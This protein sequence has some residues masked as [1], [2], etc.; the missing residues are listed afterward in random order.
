MEDGEVQDENTI[1]IYDQALEWPGDDEAPERRVPRSPG[2]VF[3]LLVARSSI[4]PRSQRLA[5]I[6]TA[7]SEVQLGRDSAPVGSELPRIRLKE[8]EVSKVHATVYWDGER[9]EW[10]VVDMGSKHGTFFKSSSRLGTSGSGIGVDKGVRLS[11]ERIASVPRRLGHGDTLTIGGTAF[12]I[13][14]HEDG[15]PCGDCA[16]QGDDEIPLFNIRASRNQQDDGEQSHKRKIDNVDSVDAS[17]T[18]SSSG[19]DPKKAL[20]MLKKSLLSRHHLVD[21][22]A[23]FNGSKSRSPTPSNQY[24]D[25]SAKRRALYPSSAPDTP[26]VLTPSRATTASPRLS[27]PFL[28]APPPALPPAPVSAPPTPLAS[29]NIGHQLLMKQGWQPGTSLGDPRE[30]RV[31]AALIEPLEVSVNQTRAGLGMGSGP[32]DQ[33]ESIVGGNLGGDWREEAK[34]R[35]WANTRFG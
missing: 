2:P 15:L 31:G 32:N 34:R 6:D 23:G 11:P 21:S 3:R 12:L 22:H 20:T 26:G 29:T 8:M 18:S 35:R 7:Y 27:S 5:V 30:E 25:R 4:L 24:V 33:K 9:K 14:L 13:H 17:P 10:G 19:R 16:S 1:A 28:A